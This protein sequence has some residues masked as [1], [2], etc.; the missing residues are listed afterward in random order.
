MAHGQVVE[1][2]LSDR[3]F[4]AEYDELFEACPDAFIQQSTYWAEAIQ[5]LGPDR[6][7]FLLYREGD[8]AIAGLPLYL[9][10][11]PLGNIL[12]SVPQPGPLGGIFF[13]EGLSVAKLEP[14]FASLL[15]RAQELAQ[16]NRCISM[17]IITNPFFQDIEF[18]RKYLLPSFAFE[19]FTQYIWVGDAIQEGKIILRDYNRRSNLSRN[20]HKAR[21]NGLEVAP[22]ATE[23]DVDA[24]LRIH[25][26]RFGELEALP[27]DPQLFRGILNVL[28]PRGKACLLLAKKGGRVISGGLY[29]RHRS[30]MDVFMLCMDS[31][32]ADQGPNFLNTEQSLLMAHRMGVQRYNWQSSPGRES[33]VYQHKKQWG[34]REATYYFVTKL[35]CEPERIRKIGLDALKSKYTGHY[36][37][38]YAAFQEGFDK[39]DFRKA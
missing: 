14:V 30:V 15:G 6:P 37:V 19:N 29:V 24:W 28:G 4:R 3:R 11:H 31:E 22:H 20:L 35:F 13:R 34:S 7:I 16:A 26:K 17:T 39:N 21:E 36:V 25:E 33:G 38:P 23:A 32:Y 8:T 2:D 10:E 27:L 5:E 18:Y 9:Y 1:G 12:T